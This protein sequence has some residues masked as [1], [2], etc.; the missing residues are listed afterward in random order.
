MSARPTTRVATTLAAA[1]LSVLATV[2]TALPA[3]ANS[4]NG[5]IYQGSYSY[6]DGEDRFC[7]RA[8]EV[9]IRDRAIIT[10]TLTPYD[11]SRGPTITFSDI[12]YAGREC[13]SLARA[14]EDT[15]YKAAIKSSVSFDRE[16]GQTTYV[17]K[18][19]SFYS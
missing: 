16:T 3:S 2:A 4:F 19:V 6:N 9:N 15:R 7:L 1:S 5:R 10:V 14:Y 13:R 17:R 12:D 18:T 8:D 11:T